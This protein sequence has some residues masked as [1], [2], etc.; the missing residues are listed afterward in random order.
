VVYDENRAKIIIEKTHIYTA[1]VL[2][3][4]PM[5]RGLPNNIKNRVELREQLEKIGGKINL[6]GDNLAVEFDLRIKKLSTDT[7]STRNQVIRLEQEYLAV[8]K[9]Q[10]DDEFQ[11]PDVVSRLTNDVTLLI[12]KSLQK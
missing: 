12:V 10:V 3:G 6:S 2:K 1:G 5:L 8:D 9:F 7:L 4:I 11:M